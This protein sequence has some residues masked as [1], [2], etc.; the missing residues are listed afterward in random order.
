VLFSHHYFSNHFLTNVYR[1]TSLNQALPTPDAEPLIANNAAL[2]VIAP[3]HVDWRT[4]AVTRL[5]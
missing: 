1:P 2:A 5:A 4:L 3:L